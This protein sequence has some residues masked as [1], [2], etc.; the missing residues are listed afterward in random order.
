MSAD[1]LEDPCSSA[2][3]AVAGSADGPDDPL[4]LSG[5]EVPPRLSRPGRGSRLTIRGGD[6]TELVARLGCVWPESAVT[7][8]RR[9]P[10]GV[11]GTSYLVLPSLR[12]P[13]LLVPA[14]D[15]A[16]ATALRRV[17]AGQRAGVALRALAW[18]QQRRLLRLLPLVRLQVRAPD[19]S[20]V[21]G[22]VRAAVPEAES[23]VVRL[24]RRRHGRAVVLQALSRDGRSLAFAKCASGDRVA[25]LRA[26]CQR[27]VQL[28][29]TPAPGVRA[30][31]VLDFRDADGTAVLVLE[32]L[33]PDHPGVATSAP[34][35]AMR[36]LAER[37]GAVTTSLSGT[38]VMARL[39]VGIDGLADP[40][41]RTRLRLELDRLLSDLGDVAIRTG[42]WHGDW[43]GWNMARDRDT[44]LLW[45]WEH[46]EAGV[47]LGLD[48][49]HYLAQD[50]RIHLGTSRSIE[51]RWLA[52]ARQGLRRD[53]G[54][55]GAAA[56]ATLR[57]Y[58]I[59][60][61]LRFVEDRQGDPG[62]PSRR[63]GWSDDLLARL[64]SGHGTGSST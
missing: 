17:D 37:A 48:H 23:L 4:V 60:V 34:V 35:S 20:A 1:P 38:D 57:T 51:D 16:A 43:V 31:R 27:L 50:L 24:G 44:V 40:R 63:E 32:A 14:D 42:T 26:E 33:V 62:G 3:P 13:V 64:W 39:R 36:A 47:P 29:E 56:E 59:L 54:V 9:S 61:N 6:A 45:D 10:S 25:S 2:Q 46:A 12:R 8:A 58:L 30:P 19:A 7:C 21:V 18:A 52:M 15:P 11:N 28:G 55:V 53:W 49:L 41:V 5:T 22:V